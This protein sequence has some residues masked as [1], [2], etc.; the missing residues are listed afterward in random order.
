MIYVSTACV[1]RNK[2]CEILKDYAEH[3]IRNI[4]LSGGTRYYD[5]LEN[6][7]LR[8]QSEYGLTY[9]CHAYFPP[10]KEDFVVNLASCNDEIYQHSINHYLECIELLR[11]MNCK[12]LSVHAGFLIEVGVQE[13]G[14]LIANYV[15][16]DTET[17][18]DRFCSAYKRIEECANSYGIDMFLEN[19][20]VSWKNYLQWG[21]QN[22][23]LMTDYGSIMEMKRKMDFQLLLD[24]G[25]L[26][27][28][29]NSLG[30]SFEGQL[31]KLS[32]QIQW[33]HVSNNNSIEDEH[34]ILS[35]GDQIISMLQKYG[36][37][38]IPITLEAKG[39]IEEVVKCYRL[40]ENVQHDMRQNKEYWE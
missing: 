35:D 19:N 24:L 23:M 20:V 38:N 4:E 27:V 25:H 8:L 17:A 30:L 33:F 18:I 37:Q 13:I 26:K 11:I 40:L 39:E 2:I 9:A 7:L 14:K 10:P 34:R 28:S 16:Y 6:D 21:M 31:Q 22:H 5:G 29:S 32:P 15:T 3:G 1:K 36:R 12:V